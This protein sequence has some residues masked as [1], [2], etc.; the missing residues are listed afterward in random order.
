MLEEHHDRSSLAELEAELVARDKTI[1]VLI[2]RVEGQFARTNSSIAVLERNISLE[3]QVKRRTRELEESHADLTRTL[4]ELRSAQAQLLESKKLEAIGQLAAGIAHEINTPVQYVSHN[5]TFLDVAF[6]RLLSVVEATASVV[7]EL[8]AKDTASPEVRE[9]G[10]KFQAMK[11]DW[12]RAEVPRALAESMDGLARVAAIVGAMKEFSHPSAMDKQLVDLHDAISATVT[13]A[14]HEWKY[15]A[16]VETRFDPRISGVPC[17]RNEFNQVVLNLVVNA[18]HAISERTEGG[19]LGKGRIVIMTELFEQD[20]EIRV[21]DDGVGISKEV[22]TRI[23][24]PFFTTKPVGKGTG[25][26]LAISRSVIVD[27]HGGSIRV[28]SSPGVGTCFFVRLPRFDRG[29]APSPARAV[30]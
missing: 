4:T 14:R 3:Q 26:G 23:Y 6:Q 27:K 1:G 29:A 15:V 11:L 13:V 25:Q 20:V 5:T 30:A 19:A 8:V 18:A 22:E 21:Q 28:E 9:L 10:A 24:D 16:D 7:Q 12:L 2:A 17:L